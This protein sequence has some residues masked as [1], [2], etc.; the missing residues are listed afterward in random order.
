M[1]KVQFNYV[2]KQGGKG[3]IKQFIIVFGLVV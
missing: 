2:E 3:T 1:I